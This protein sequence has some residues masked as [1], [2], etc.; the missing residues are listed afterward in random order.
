MNKSG[1]CKGLLFAVTSYVLAGC[2]PGS[3]PA[4]IENEREKIEIWTY[5]ETNAQCSAL[6]KVIEGFNRSQTVYEASWQYV[7]MTE[8][9]KRL[10][11]AYTERALPDLAIIDNPDMPF[12]IK[13]GM[14]EDITDFLKGLNVKEEYYPSVLETVTYAGHMYGLPVNCNNAALIYNK[15]M[16]AEQ[17]IKPPETWDELE[18]AAAALA[19]EERSG[20]LMCGLEGE[21]GAFQ[22]LPWI[23]SAG[24]PAGEIG[25]EGTERAFTFLNNLIA[26]DYMTKDCINLSQNDVA[27]VFVEGKT[28]MM[29]NGPWV[30]PMLEEA[31]IAYGVSPLPVDK[32]SSVIVGG[33]N[34]GILKGKNVEGA[35][36][37]IEYYNQDSVMEQFCNEA[38]LLPPKMKLETDEA[39]NLQ[40]FKEQMPEALVRSS[41][42]SW[43]ALSK[44]LSRSIYRMVAEQ[45]SPKEAADKLD[46]QQGEN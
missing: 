27:R 29:E 31:G 37:F 17:K 40:V 10:S 43:N 8:F 30:F 5:Y 46:V 12:C 32:I 38:Q 23:L 2:G 3:P 9:T 45:K 21:Q 41:I 34:M 18:A 1:I 39:L 42:P 13:M 7:P 36:K 25:G 28:A 33:E 4:Q 24:E 44:Q 16:L 11:M 35:K 26:N 15:E 22:I 6:D 14:F 20:F 19:T